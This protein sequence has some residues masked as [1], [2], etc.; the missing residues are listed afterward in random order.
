MMDMYLKSPFKMKENEKTIE[1]AP[2]A[3][4]PPVL[5]KILYEDY[6]DEMYL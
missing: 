4:I 3:T 6:K 5:K 1:R 2:I